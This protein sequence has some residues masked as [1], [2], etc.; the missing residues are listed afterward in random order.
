MRFNIIRAYFKKEIIELYRTK[1]ILMPYIMP[2]MIVILFGY[3]IKMQVTGVRILIIDNDH[4]KI[5][6]MLISKFEHSKYFHATVSNISEK[7]ALR[8]IKQASKDLVLII[9]SS[10]EKNIYKGIKS[11]IGVFIDAS[12][13]SRA[14][15]I[16]N[17]VQGVILN[18]ADEF[19]V[20]S[21]TIKLNN[22]NLFNQALRDEEMIVPGLIGLVL[23]VS[24]AILTA[25]I[26]AKEKEKGTIFNFYSSSVT[27]VEFLIAKLSAVFTLASFNIFILF[28]LVLYV[29]NLPFRGNFFL[30][31]LSSEIYI[32]VSLG[33]GLLVSIVASTQIVAVVVTLMLTILP[34]F[35][36]SGMLMP[37]S[38]MSG[39][40]YIIAH[41]YPV[42]Y[43]NHIIYDTFLIAQGFNSPKI[44]QYL[45]L[46]V[47]YAV[48]LFV[49][50]ILFLKKEIKL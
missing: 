8:K 6:N 30:Y 28:V 17:Y 12:F 19:Y 43:Y 44:I 47:C 27:K 29:F 24:P 39:G 45:C 35:L 46:L 22:R 10:F 38:S 23:L 9:P 20:K 5:S 34:G 3:G 14:T 33:F 37:I 32:L 18:L 1:M 50:G 7:E 25:L 48:L 49:L 13:P 42:M 26:I 31:W 4:S 15:T 16:S 21:S 11:E 2:L 36:Y 41:I 40:A